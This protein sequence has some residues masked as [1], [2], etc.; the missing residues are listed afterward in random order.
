VFQHEHLLASLGFVRE[1]HA[2][3]ACLHG[4]GIPFLTFKGAA[5]AVQFYGDASGREYSDIDLIVPRDRVAEAERSLAS[6][7][8]RSEVGEPRLREAFLGFQRQYQLAHPGTG[9]AID[10]HWDF[11]G[12]HV[13]FPLAAGDAWRDGAT[14][15]FGGRAL[16]TLSG[17]NLALLLAGHGTKEQ[18]RS[19]E[20][21]CDFA[22]M[23]DRHPHLD[24]REVHR[25]A[26]ARGS[27]RVA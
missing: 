8:Y 19:L 18:W 24:W 16:R 12:D 27:G 10:L 7:G 3:A 6:L 5:L 20:L 4:A 26:A 11:S 2:V 14:V 9:R 15:S 25:R 17:E 13:P 23:V 1:L 21:V 22:W